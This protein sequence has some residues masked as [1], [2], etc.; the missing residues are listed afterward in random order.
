MKTAV[1]LN[2][3]Q[4][5]LLKLIAKYRFVT[6][7][8]VQTYFNLKSRGGVFE[9]LNVMV[10]AGYLAVRYDKSF[11]LQYR[12]AA[13]YLMPK[14]LREVQKQLPY[15]TETII[16]N[17]Y[18][19]KNASES[20]IQKSGELFEQARSLSH[21][22]PEMTVLTARQLGDF[23]YFPKPLPDLYI[24]RKADE[25]T[26]RFFLFNLRDVKRYDL[27]V[28][29]CIKKLVAY[30]EADTYAE[31]GNEFPT[32]LFVCHS[33]SIERLVQRTVRNALNKSYESIL[34]YTTSYQ[35]LIKQEGANQPIWSSID[36][37]D[38]LLTLEEVE[39]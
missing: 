8:N 5:D 34:A 20:L 38:T 7:A 27:A 10:K 39:A 35:A 33:A 13:Y 31:S 28:R 26:K 9:K 4:Y 18:S 12:P 30:R 19:D 36:D 25:E 6:V 24:A 37:P 3:K 1:S 23:D 11:K 22:Y 32:V 16:R 17:A 29:S 14:G 15:I 2:Q 21:N